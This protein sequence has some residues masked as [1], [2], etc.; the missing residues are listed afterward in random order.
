MVKVDLV[1]TRVVP[2]VETGSCTVLV[3]DPDN[4]NEVFGKANRGDFLNY[5]VISRDYDTEEEDWEFELA[6]DDDAEIA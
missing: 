5:L 1:F 3:K 2:V 4:M 6:E